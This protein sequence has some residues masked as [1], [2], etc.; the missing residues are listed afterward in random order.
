MKRFVTMLILMG[1]LLCGTV[2]AEGQ[3]TLTVTA[4]DCAP[5]ETIT[6][7]FGVAKDSNIA[8]ANF[9]VTYDTDSFE[10]SAY[11]DGEAVANCMSVG[12]ATDGKFL[13]A[14]AGTDPI[15]EGGTLF[16]VEFLVDSAASGAHTFYFYTTSCC[17][18]DLNNIEVETVSAV[19]TVSGQA[20]SDV[21]VTPVTSQTEDGSTVA[22]SADNGESAT[23][24]LVSGGAK[25]P[26]D[27]QQ[28][29]GGT[30]TGW[31][32]AG[33]VVVLIIVVAVLIVL[34]VARTKKNDDP[35]QHE[36]ILDPEARS[37]LDMTPDALKQ[38][39]SDGDSDADSK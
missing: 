2:M 7:A 4:K 24:L 11:E 12:N 17:D 14:M 26:T 28:E 18:A 15:T 32:I 33:V 3:A 25:Q 34:A 31:L 36:S 29:S 19:V 1:I 35:Q 39:K 13:Y 27:N 9:E 16:T 38:E 23:G 8:A 20:V 21:S 30:A 37:L 5:G 6:L 22:V 10:Y